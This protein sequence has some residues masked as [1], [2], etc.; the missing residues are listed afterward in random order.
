[1]S[2]ASSI[3]VGSS[4]IV[5]VGVCDLSRIVGMSYAMAALLLLLSQLRELVQCPPLKIF[6]K[7]LV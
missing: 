2:P 7:L 4:I 1:M 5:D 3:I 6:V